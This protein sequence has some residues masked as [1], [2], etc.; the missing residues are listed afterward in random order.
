MTP[1]PATIANGLI[2]RI[3]GIDAAGHWSAEISRSMMREAKKLR[4]VDVS[5]GDMVI[6]MIHCIDGNIPAMRKAFKNSIAFGPH[7]TTPRANFALAL[8]R[9]GFLAEALGIMQD[10]ERRRP[11]TPKDYGLLAMICFGLGLSAK[12]RQYQEISDLDDY[13]FAEE[14][15]SEILKHSP[16][17]QE[18]IDIVTQS[19]V[20][21]SAIWQSLANR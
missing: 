14:R 9:Q 21:D 4:E 11:F 15:W 2:D 16:K 12:A 7:K 18:A 5:E 17:Q 13:G 20:R 10:E 1:I 19:L 6:G 8:A 3:S